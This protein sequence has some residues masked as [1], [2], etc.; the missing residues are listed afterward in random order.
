MDGLSAGGF[1]GVDFGLMANIGDVPLELLSADAE[2]V[3]FAASFKPPTLEA[4]ARAAHRSFWEPGRREGEFVY[5]TRLPVAVGSTYVARCVD[6]GN[7]DLLVAFRVLRK[8]SDGSVVLLW[9]MLQEFPTPTLQRNVE[10]A[11]AQ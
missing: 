7:S 4:D 1:G 11:D 9:K 5:K 10:A 2:A 8:D 3:R 6:Y